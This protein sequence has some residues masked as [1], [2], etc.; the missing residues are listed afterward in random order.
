MTVRVE[1]H[2]ARY[3]EQANLAKAFFDQAKTHPEKMF[4]FDKR[5][6]EWRGLSW[7][8]VA[9]KI[10]RVAQMLLDNGIEAGDRVMIASENRSE[11]AISELA[12]MSVGGIAVPAYTTY[13]EDDHHYVLDHSGAKMVFVSG[14][15]IAQR[16]LLAAQRAHQVSHVITFNKDETFTAGD[17]V[18]LM[19]FS[20]LLANTAPVADMDTLLSGIDSDDTCCFIY[21]SGTG[22]RPKGV[23]L[24]HR[25]IQANIKAAIELLAEADIRYDERFLSL[26]PQFAWRWHIFENHAWHLISKPIF[27]SCCWVCL[28]SALISRCSIR[29]ANM[30]PLR[31]WQWCFPPHPWSIFC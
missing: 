31:C 9:D 30:L 20:A 22:G 26:L 28:F 5:D 2:M 7:A 6:G 1:G 16:V 4:L 13:T 21:T 10:S 29:L 25:N 8:E 19:D 18:K 24:T 11:W 14:G 17:K 23:M 15:Q 12:I 27:I 3:V